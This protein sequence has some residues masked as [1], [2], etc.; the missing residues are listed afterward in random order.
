MFREILQLL[1]NLNYKVTL[2]E[3]CYVIREVDLDKI[4]EVI[5]CLDSNKEK[6]I[7]KCYYDNL[8]KTN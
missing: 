6:K 5:S 4:V 7:I 2:E 3:N 8:M 1:K